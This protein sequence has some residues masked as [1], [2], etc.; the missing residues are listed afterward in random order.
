MAKFSVSCGGTGGHVFPGVATAIALR[1]RGHDVSLW[2]SGKAIET[3][4]RHAWTGPVVETG[5]QI[6]TLHPLRLPRTLIDF[7]RAYL[8]S[9]RAL[10]AEHPQAM[11]AMGSY[12][13]VPPVLAA[14]H[15]NI[16]VVLHEANVIPGRAVSWLS[17]LADAVAITFPE[18]R[19]HLSHPRLTLTGLPLRQSLEES[20]GQALPINGA[21]RFTLLVMGG[22]QGARHLNEVIP[23]AVARMQADGL[24]VA[25]IHLAGAKA[26]EQVEAAYQSA[27]VPAVVYGFCSDMASVY[28]QADLAL[29]RSGANSCME[30]AL[31]GIP[32]ILVPYPHSARDHQM[33]NARAMARAGAAEILEQGNMTPERLD[34]VIRSRYLQPER[35][36]S[37][38]VAARRR[39]V[40]G[41]S[42]HLADLVEA[43]A[44]TR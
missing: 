29:S 19:D 21:H 5:A 20:S 4:T 35:L 31:F 40:T 38:R 41:A 8:T 2:M 32:A 1:Q 18:T 44:T 9:R 24:S 15:M 10:R 34:H 43:V 13:C 37:M 42:Q 36:E 7:T 16:P 22:S 33:A 14:R 12:S 11:L 39:A 17:S 26:R 28:R 3:A 23:A 25:V 6:L 27:G 30:L